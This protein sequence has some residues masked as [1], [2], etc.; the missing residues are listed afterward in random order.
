[1]FLSSSPLNWLNLWINIMIGFR[2]NEHHQLHHLH[3]NNWIEQPKKETRS[4]FLDFVK[5]SQEN[6]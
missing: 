5:R 6:G 3:L 4:P 2:Y 1:M